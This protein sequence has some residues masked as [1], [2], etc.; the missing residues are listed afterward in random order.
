M[1]R[2]GLADVL[3]N[4]L[5][6]GHHVVVTQLLDLGDARDIESGLLLD[7]GEIVDRD[8]AQPHP[9]LDGENLDLEPACELRTLGEDRSHLLTAVSRDHPLIVEGGKRATL[10]PWSRELSTVLPSTTTATRSWTPEALAAQTQT[11]GEELAGRGRALEIGVGTGRIALPLH[12]AGID[13]VGLDLSR[14]MMARL[15]SKAGGHPPPLVEGDATTLPFADGAFGGAISC[16]VLH[17]IP[18][19][20]DV[21]GELARVLVPGGVFLSDLGGWTHGPYDEVQRHF[22]K[23]AGIVTAKQFVGVRHV[24][25]LDEA[26]LALGAQ[27]RPLQALTDRRPSTF[28]E[29][30]AQLEDG[31]WSFTWSATPETRAKAAAETRAWTES[32]YGPLDTEVFHE[33]QVSWRAYDFP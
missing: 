11:L 9:R 32:R 2:P 10:E 24:E 27:A 5:D 21:L 18:E 14:P 29:L 6:E 22:T 25:E 20:R 33:L 7:L 15:V 30:I 16:H 8:F 17:L 26:M 23:A 28:E 4:V 3:A 12:E 1:W 13:L 19:W 31:L